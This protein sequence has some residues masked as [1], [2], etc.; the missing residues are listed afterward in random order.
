MNKAGI[1]EGVAMEIDL[2][3]GK[4]KNAVLEMKVPNNEKFNFN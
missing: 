4:L 2:I 1:Y 3:E